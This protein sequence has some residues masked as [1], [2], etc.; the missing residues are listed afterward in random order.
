MSTATRTSNTPSWLPMKAFCGSFEK[1]RLV[2]LDP[3]I[4]NQPIRRDILHACVTWYRDSIRSGTASTKTRGEVARSGRK[5]R[6][7]KGTGRA[8]L[9]DAGSPMLRGGGRAFGPKPRDFSTELPKKIRELGLKIAFS[10]KLRERKLIVVPSVEWPNWKTRLVASQL[11][12]LCERKEKG[13]LVVTGMEAVPKGLERTTRNLKW[14]TCK[15]T[16]ELQ[17]WDVLKS[18]YTILSLEALQWLQ[19]NLGKLDSRPDLGVPEE[20]RVHAVDAPPEA[21]PEGQPTL[22]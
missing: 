10:A 13:C 8:R 22:T 12:G 9:G 18:T 2:F 4:F 3:T 11:R 14:V 15:T 20:L 6:P 17:V 19:A 21:R 5:L 7:Q 16:R 1:D